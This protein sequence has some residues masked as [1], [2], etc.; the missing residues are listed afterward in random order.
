MAI[1][2]SALPEDLRHRILR[3]LPLRDAIRTSVLAQGWRRLWESRWAHPTSC[4]NVRILPGDTPAKTLRS[5]D[6]DGGPPRRLDRFSLV[7]YSS[8]FRL[9]Y[10]N[11]LLKDAAK[12]CVGDLHVELHRFGVFL[13]PFVF[14]M[15]LMYY[16][17]AQPFHGLEVIRLHSIDDNGLLGSALSKMLSLCPRLHT[18]DLRKCSFPTLFGAKPFIVPMLEN[19]RSITIAEC[20]GLI[21]VYTKEAPRDVRE[22][23]RNGYFRY[24]TGSHDMSQRFHLVKEAALLAHF[25]GL[26][27]FRYGGDYAKSPF[28]LKEAALLTKLYI[29]L[30]ESVTDAR[31]FNRSLPK[32]LS[33]L[34]VL[35]IC[36]NTLKITSS[37]LKGGGNVEHG[38]LRNLHSLKELQLLMFRMKIDNLDDIALFLKSCQ[39]Q[40]ANLE[41]LFVQLPATSDAT[42]KC[43]LKETKEVDVELPGNSLDN[44]RIAKVMNFNWSCSEV[45][46]VCFLLRKAS[47]LN[48]LLLVS[49]NV[50]ASPHVTCVPKADL[51]LL[52]KAF[53]NDLIIVNKCDDTATQPFYSEVFIK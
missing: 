46:L 6:L 8:R 52:N 27:S 35:T 19:L 31:Q 25:P 15:P 26:R 44:L 40:C 14:N 50:T 13:Q 11:C 20:R 36:S 17:D 45:Q 12:R 42:S 51:L 28:N 1:H 33:A 49:S 5:L 34:T 3:H 4:R 32:D 16:K 24:T 53:A 23:P 9:P 18:L 43:L 47:S 38:K 2:I 30:R 10:L 39:C 41:R 22:V 37:L 21:F 48:K 7:V 29:C